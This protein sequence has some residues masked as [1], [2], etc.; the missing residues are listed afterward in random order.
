MTVL[1]D[2]SWYREIAENGYPVPL[3]VDP[4]TGAVSQNAWAFYPAFP[5]LSRLLMSVTGLGFPVVASTLALVCGAG[6]AVLWPCCCATGWDPA[7]R[8]PRCWSTPASSRRRSCRWP[9]PSPSRCCCWSASSRARAGAVAGRLGPRAGPRRHPADRGATGA[10]RR[11][12]RSSCAG[13][14][15]PASG[16]RAVSCSRW[17]RCWRRA[18]WPGWRGRRSPGGDGGALGLHRH[19]GDVALDRRGQ[20]LRPWLDM[21]RYLGGDTWGPT[22]LAVWWL[23]LVLMVL[24]P[25][26]RASGRACAPGAWPT[27]PTSPSCWTR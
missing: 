24:G 10:G 5:L 13:A 19:D 17:A 23:A 9:T 25:W 14:A 18:A 11:W 21:R 7:S 26:A 16:C 6:A 4:S 20:P 22:G 15:G 1:W 3:P 8:S 27:R 2:G 12:S